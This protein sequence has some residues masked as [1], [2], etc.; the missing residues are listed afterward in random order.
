MHDPS[1]CGSGPGEFAIGWELGSVGGH[2][3]I[4]HPGVVYGYTTQIT[5]VP[6]SKLGVVV[7]TNGRTDPG[8][9]A[10]EMLTALLAPV[11]AA[12]GG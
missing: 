1:S 6:D 11:R 2:G 3:T 12:A 10:N 8:G 9:L 5:L 7:F 4:G